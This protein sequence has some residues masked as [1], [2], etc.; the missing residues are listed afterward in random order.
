MNIIYII[1][2]LI[3]DITITINN[4]NKRSILLLKTYYYVN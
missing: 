4:N 3:G 2:F 1:L